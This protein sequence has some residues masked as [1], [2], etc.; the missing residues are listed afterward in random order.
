MTTDTQAVVAAALMQA[1]KECVPADYMGLS[2]EYTDGARHAKWDCH[3]RILAMIPADAMAA[4][5]AV[6]AEA[7]KDVVGM[8]NELLHAATELAQLASYSEIVGG[9]SHNRPHIRKWCD[10][11]FAIRK[12]LPEDKNYEPSFAAMEG[13]Q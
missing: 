8:A 11:V 6:K 10:E 5:E 9:I 13:K 4:L 12:R 2:G 7:R 3:N 1:A